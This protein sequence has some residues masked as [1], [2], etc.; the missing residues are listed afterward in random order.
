MDPPGSAAGVGV[1][2]SMDYAVLAL[3]GLVALGGL[4]AFALGHA[5]WSWGTVIAGLLVLLTA[6]GYLYLVT[7][8]AARERAWARVITRYETDLA[9]VRDALQPAP[10]GRLTSLP[11]Q[12]SIAALRQQRD[13]WRRALERARD[14]QGR[15]WPGASFTPPGE[16]GGTGTIEM[17]PDGNAADAPPFAVGAVVFLFDDADHGDG[18]RYIGQFRVT[19]VEPRGNRYVLTVVETAVRDGYDARVLESPHPAVT[20]YEDLPVDRWLAFYRTRTAT[21]AEAPATD[22]MPEP[23][24][25]P[26]EVVK[27]LMESGDEVDRLIAGFIDTFEQHEEPVPEDQWQDVATRL[28]AG[29]VAH[30]TYWADVE[31][32]AAHE[33]TEGSEEAKRDYAKGE[34]AE[35]DLETALD[36]RDNLQ[37]AKIVRLVYRRPLADMVTL[38]HG[39]RMEV[40]DGPVQVDGAANLMRALRQERAELEAAAGR[41]QRTLAAVGET[42]AG[43]NKVA[44]ELA[45]D[46]ESWRRDVA[47]AERLRERFETA[48]VTTTADRT[49]AEQAIVELGRALAGAFATLTAAID[50]VAPPPSPR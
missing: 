3:V 24:K 31:F 48:V 29:S 4:V 35:F 14:W 41:L 5:R 19:T 28:A 22:V 44:D 6:G 20:V 7:R 49:A 18:G 9:R 26:V 34:R 40:K 12:L 46:L 21:D 37:K 25:S 10:G 43:T 50:R 15:V 27:E 39:S 30:G 11:D 33:F 2:D 38:L 36:L 13:R 45:A 32:T 42:T 23:V 17:A 16:A 8:L 1:A 47:A